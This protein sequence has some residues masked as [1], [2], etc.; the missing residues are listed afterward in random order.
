MSTRWI[1]TATGKDR[2]GI[3]AGVTKIL[4]QLGCNLEDS[5]MTRLGGEFTVMLAFSAS[6]KAGPERLR[7]AFAPLER[8]LGLAVHLKALTASEARAPRTRGR[9]YQISVYGA[10]RPGIVYRVTEALAKRGV[11]ILDVHAHRS[12]SKGPSLYLLMLEVEM[13]SSRPAKSIELQLKRVAK[14]LGVQLSLRPA[15]ADVL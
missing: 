7:R 11:N 15:E 13:P 8:R 5:A 2:P 1:V 4:Y 3:V 9:P 6:A 12:A 14:Q 10:D